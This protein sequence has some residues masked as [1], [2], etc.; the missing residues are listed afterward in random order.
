MNKKF[1][2]KTF[3]IV[4][5]VSFVLSNSAML[6]PQKVE[7]VITNGETNGEW[8]DSSECIAN[9]C[10]TSEGTKKQTWYEKIC[11]YI[12]PTLQFEASGEICP[13]NEN[14]YT[15]TDSSKA[16]K[17]KVSGE[18]QYADKITETF[19]PIDVVYGEK[20]QDPN[21][22]HR[23]TALSL[24]VPNWAIS[25]Y[26]DQLKEL[27]DF[28]ETNCRMEDT[29]ETQIVN[30]CN[31]EIVPCDSS[32]ATIIAHK[33]VCKDE[34]DLPNWGDGGLDIDANTA[35]DWVNTHPNCRLADNWE[36]EWAYGNVS[37][38]GDNNI[39]PT[40]GNWNLFSITNPAVITDLQK[41]DKIWVREVFQDGYIPF[42]G[43]TS[44]PY[45]DENSA[46]FY[47]YQ[48]VL[49]YDNYDRIDSPQI[50]QIYYCVGFNAPKKSEVTVCKTDDQRNNL[51]GW[52]VALVSEENVDGP[53]SIN[54]SNETGTNSTSLPV[55][56]YLIKVSGT[57]RYGSSAMIA[58]AGYS[59]RPL[60]IPSGCD[61][62]L[63]GF[64]LTSGSNGL[65]AWING[66][67]VYWGP[68]V[69][70]HTYTTIYHHEVAGP[71]NI[72]IYDDVYGD[73]LNNNNFS[74]E[75]FPIEFQGN[76]GNEGCITFSGVP[77]G[78]YLL[79]EENREGWINISGLGQVVIDE[80][81]ETFNIVNH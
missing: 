10:G 67:P 38:P 69:N 77:Y 34:A 7:A 68:F 74:F 63:S 58:D 79:D 61:C 41:S 60:S 42:S 75:I 6:I 25:A 40:G 16:C 12:C 35:S 62:W 59:Y 37:N 26:N 18:W 21:H 50:G 1:L 45:D 27:E 29:K 23:P 73:N 22:C 70:N 52:Q 31:A 43:D 13:E 65:M 54:V 5:A 24:N 8:R 44:S 55:G 33:I 51:S 71:V 14:D 11:G 3:A 20:S 46:E 64:D 53:T 56:Y 76:T 39:G 72:S 57:Y 78:S 15:S 47:C 36:F 4:L 48:D 80:S 19:G 17:K 2:T 30:C 28:I 32:I 81:E 9:S 49:N 66:N